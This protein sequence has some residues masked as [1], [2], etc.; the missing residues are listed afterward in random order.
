MKDELNVVF[1]ASGA[2][3]QAVVSE[4]M[5]NN[6][7]IRAVERKKK[8]IL[9]VETYNAD[10]LDLSQAINAVKGATHVYLCIGITYSSKIWL[11]EWPK[12]MENIII[13]CEK[14]SAR[15][16]YLDNVYMY[17]PSPLKVPFDESHQQI[18][19]SQKG[20]ARKKASDLLMEA[21]QAGRVKAVIGRSADFYGPN[22]VNSSFYLGFLDRML[23]GKAP[24]S[25]GKVDVKHT[26]S[27]TLD[28]GRALVALAL[29]DATYGQ[30]WHLPV[31]EPVTMEEIVIKFNRIFGS[32]YKIS[33]IPRF[34]T[35]ILG[36]FVPIIWEAKEM[37]Y[38][39][40]NPYIMNYD[41][42]KNHFPDFKT[43]SL[44]DG[45]STMIQSFKK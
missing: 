28:N 44:D 3:G 34:I 29:D 18:P 6:L 38:Q 45:I 8:T 16:I 7:K 25:L 10:L 32:N 11:E 23:L 33:M 21:H 9:G 12:I 14:A 36:M 13:A 17:G 27:Y 40:D 26:Y 5:A 31:S 4:L 19:I 24:Q 2:I 41:K 1:G 42:F 20:I 22:A 39:F 43:T 15:L 37:L 30:I 35:G